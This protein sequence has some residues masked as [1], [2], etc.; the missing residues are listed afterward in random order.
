MGALGYVSAVA[1]L[2]SQCSTQGNAFDAIIVANGSAGTHA[3]ILA[4]LA[5]VK[6]SI[7]VH[8]ISVSGGAAAQT[9]K[10]TRLVQETASLLGIEIAN[11]EAS[12]LVH[13]G[14]VGPGY[15]LP[16]PGMYEAVAL[17]AQTEGL[18]LDPV[19]TGKAMAGLIDL[20][21]QGTFQRGQ[22]VLFWHT[23]GTPGLFAYEPQLSAALQQ[24]ADS[25]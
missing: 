2:F 1:E 13:D 7:P 5:A 19:Y 24:A 10:T 15:G 17:V 11:A 21:R 8:G 25:R 22:R 3:G 16:T 6:S 14:Y 4:G 23:G 18:L 9:T 12:V 20:I